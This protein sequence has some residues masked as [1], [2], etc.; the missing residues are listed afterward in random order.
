M[1]SRHGAV[2]LVLVELAAHLSL[3]QRA[4]PLF[5]LRHCRQPGACEKAR[6]V[7]TE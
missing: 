6:M 1:M 2:G 7:S 5:L 4:D 3:S